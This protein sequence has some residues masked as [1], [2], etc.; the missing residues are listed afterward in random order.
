MILSFHPL[1]E[2]D[3]NIN[4][5]GRA[6]GCDELAQLKAADAVILAQGCRL[7][8]YA[9]SRENCSL[10]FPSYDARFDYP[11]KIGQIQLFHQ[12]GVL[13]PESEAFADTD[14]FKMHYPR[15]PEDLCF[16]FPFVFKF[17]WGGEGETVH[18]IDSAEKLKAIIQKARAFE[19]TGQKGFLIQEYVP[20]RQRT[21]R[22]IVIGRRHI[23]YWRVQRSRN[24][25]LTNLSQG[26]Q[27]DT[28]SDPDQQVKAVEAVKVFCRRTQIDLAG[29]DILF[30]TKPDQTA[31]YFL[32]I[33]YFF[34]RR[35][36]GGSE[37]YYAI[38]VG[39]I[40]NWLHRHGLSLETTAKMA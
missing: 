33:N 25:F 24:I 31:P 20:C 16:E 34:G 22:V 11:G 15:S 28:E 6:P 26:A 3:K 32:E 1:F 5:A 37:K 17:D 13:C 38:L 12:A 29:F 9:M 39:E 19:H 14:M 4:C 40:K 23:S 8:L 27:I 35:G 2:A 7:D 36:L 21:L 18:L 10:V 30:S